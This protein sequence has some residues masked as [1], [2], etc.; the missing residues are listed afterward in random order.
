MSK[1]T[2]IQS[3]EQIKQWVEWLYRTYRIKRKIKKPQDRDNN[4]NLYY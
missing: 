1:N 4:G 3:A 2:A